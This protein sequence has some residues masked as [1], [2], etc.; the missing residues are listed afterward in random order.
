MLAREMVILYQGQS[1]AIQYQPFVSTSCKHVLPC[2]E[3]VY[4]VLRRVNK[5]W[6]IQL[7]SIKPLL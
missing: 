2:H 6:S 5:I 7:A 4:I 3:A 1:L